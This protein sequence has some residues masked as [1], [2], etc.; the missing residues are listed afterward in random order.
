MFFGVLSVPAVKHLVL[1]TSYVHILGVTEIR[2]S[3]R[4]G[5]THYLTLTLD[6]SR[7]ALYVGAKEVIFMLDLNNIGKEL[8]PPVS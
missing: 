7:G 6:E 8:Q 5:I 2:Q 3:W 1:N 4:G